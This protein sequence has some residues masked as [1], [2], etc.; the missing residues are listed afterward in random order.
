MDGLT[1]YRELKQLRAGT[2]AILVTACASELA[3][4]E[5]AYLGVWQI[6]KKPVDFP[7]LLGL[8]DEALRQPLVLVVDDDRDLC[9]TLW[10]LLRERGYRICLAHGVSQA[11]ERLETASY[12]VV[13]VDL[14]LPE[15]DGRA[16][17]RRLQAT[18]PQARTV[19]V[20]GYPEELGPVVE[21]AKEAGVDAVCL[22]P[23]DVPRF[24]ATLEQLSG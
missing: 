8:V 16:V 21:G 18:H 5:A 19:L 15:G 10:D 12:R 11:E 7:R 6:V 13:L 23:L 2:V 3:T 24:L 4:D 17:I 14:K 9:A 22:K 20:T 1:L